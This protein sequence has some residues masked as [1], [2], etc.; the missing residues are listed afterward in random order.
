M[1]EPWRSLDAATSPGAGGLRDY[2][3]IVT[4]VWAVLTVSGA[5]TAATVSIEGS[6]D[7]DLWFTEGSWNWSSTDAASRRVSTGCNGRYLRANLVALTGGTTPA[8]TADLWA[9]SA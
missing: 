6:W 5:P 7:G 2:E 4:S 8:V 9:E 3:E 1:S